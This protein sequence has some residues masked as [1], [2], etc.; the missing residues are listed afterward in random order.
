LIMRFVYRP[1]VGFAQLS[2]CC[3]LFGLI[4]TVALAQ[5]GETYDPAQVEN[6]CDTYDQIS[7]PE[8]VSVI[9]QRLK[10]G[11]Y[12]QA[13]I[14]GLLDEIT[15]DALGRLC[16]DSNGD[17]PFDYLALHPIPVPNQVDEEPADL[18]DN[19]TIDDVFKEYE[20][21]VGPE[22]IKKIQRQLKL[23]GY[24]PK[25]I[26]GQTGP[27]TDDA[28]AR[29]CTD[30]K[31]DEYFEAQEYT[32]PNDAKIRLAQHL[33]DLVL[34]PTINL[35]GG[36]CGC[37]RDFS[38][39]VYGFL[40]YL[41]AGVDDQEVDFSLF[42]RIGIHALALDKAGEIE[43]DLLWR[44]D[45]GNLADFVRDAHRHRVKVDVTFY[46]TNWRAWNSEETIDP[47]AE[48]IVSFA[49]QKFNKTN[50]SLWHNTLQVLVG[51]SSVS[52][53]GVNLYFDFGANSD[54]FE[55]LSKIVTGV[56]RKLEE[57]GSGAA[58]N[59]ILGLYPS[60]IDIQKL[61]EMW[62]F[63]VDEDATVDKVFI[64]L[65]EN[66]SDTSDSRRNSSKSKKELRQKIENSFSGN[67]RVTVLQKFVPI[68]TPS[69]I[70]FLTKT[71]T[72]SS[73][74]QFDDDL[75]YLK[76]NFAGVGFWPLPLESASFSED[77]T[78]TLLKHYKDNDDDNDLGELLQVYAPQVCQ[79]VCP[80][81][82]FIYIGLAVLVGIFVTYA[83][84]A[85]WNCK[86]REIYQRYFLPFSALFLS[87]P[88]I[89]V[90]SLVC[91]PAWEKYVDR[92]VI[93]ILLLF[94]TGFVWG[95]FRKAVR[96]KLP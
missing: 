68:V 12:L 41:L 57:T 48:S 33:V 37:S 16:M 60:D 83:L 43:D 58:L 46:A 36:D 7:I 25:E 64:F 15:K 61:T 75:I 76:Y 34:K 40:P 70:D 28:F 91:D 13:E 59:V 2:L 85:L 80:N 90:L 66:T 71:E 93:G 67:S 35:S 20:E 50:R 17:K 30:Y 94:I 38:S 42:D 78:E 44:S 23:G 4:T 3:L 73:A 6:F 54:K 27:H 47:V 56:S 62:S 8:Q 29:L 52:V 88:L 49:N 11:G 82:S 65:Q 31:V 89:L 55:T 77:I 92:V 14:N 53:D 74:P 51:A 69:T 84:L 24:D 72:K 79:V 18:C 26:D 96:P 81:R 21:E 9:Q 1:L 87:I 10:T 39:K 95:S 19:S 22:Q 45:N 86:L 5:S 63:L 32:D